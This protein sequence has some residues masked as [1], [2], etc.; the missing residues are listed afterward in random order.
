M[1]EQNKKPEPETEDQKKEKARAQ[2]EAAL[3]LARE[4]MTGD[5]RDCLLDFLKHDKN[6]LPWNMQGEEK[7]REIIAK[8]EQAVGGA[9]EKSVRIIA[10]D[11][12]PVMVAKLDQVVVKDGIKAVCHMSK[13]DPQRY[14]LMDAQGSEVLLV[15]TGADPYQGERKPVEISPDQKVLPMDDGDDKPIFDNT[16]AGKK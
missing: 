15:V 12:R 3:N 1:E 4:T 16:K 8:V 9:V 13:L 10:S 7:Q 14:Q 11:G 5:L 2:R 6:P